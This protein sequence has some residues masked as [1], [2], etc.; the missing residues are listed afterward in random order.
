MNTLRTVLGLLVASLLWALPRSVCAADDAGTSGPRFVVSFDAS[1]REQPVTGRLVVYLIRPDA[2]LFGGER[3]QPGDAPFFESPQP[4]FGVDV[5]GLEP[6]ASVVLDDRATSYPEVMSKLARGTYRVQAVLDWHRDNSEWKREPG[7]LYSQTS[8][9]ELDPAS[10]TPVEIKLT[11]VVKPRPTPA[12]EIAEIFEHRSELLS[13]FHGR[14]VVMKAG[15]VKPIGWTEGGGRSYAAVYEVP[16]FGGD[17]RTAFMIARGRTPDRVG[18]LPETDFKLWSNAFRIVLD[19]ESGNGHTLFADSENN[20]PWGRALVEELIPAL[21]A[22][23]GLIARPEA[24]LVTGHS[25]GGWSSL[26]LQVTYPDFFGGAW[27]SA[28]DPVDFRAFQRTDIYSAAS[29]YEQ[30]IEGSEQTALT[31]S[32]TTLKGETTMTVRTENLVEEVI[33]PRNTSGQQWDSWLAV[34]APRNADGLPAD[35]YDPR[36]GRLDRTVAERMRKYDIGELLRANPERIGRVIREKVRLVVGEK[37][38]YGLQLAVKL[39]KDDLDRLSPAREGDSGYIKVLPGDHGTVMMNP[40]A[41]G[42]R[43][44][45]LEQ[46]RSSGVLE[47]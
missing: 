6:G 43:A 25:S 22:K 45:M 11:E 5:K 24:R 41:K 37:D 16:G 27:P 23:F 39:L 42:G 29:M 38:N 21:E 44:E 33:G 20:G 40:E 15:V 30:V 34:S 7:N 36:T 14:E 10:D 31:P 35:L 3:V 32:Y 28:P 46:L 1:V 26:W 47:R 4:C 13:K 12:S 18:S 2:I 9:V 8:E 19:P 17:S